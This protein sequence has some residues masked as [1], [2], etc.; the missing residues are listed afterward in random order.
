MAI[1][2][3]IGIIKDSVGILLDGCDDALLVRQLTRDLESLSEIESF[4]ELRVW[5]LNRGKYCACVQVVGAEEGS[6]ALEKVKRIF[7]RRE[8]QSFV[9]VGKAKKN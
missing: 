9:E 5:S 6:D 7:E 2:S 1:Y 3:T 8:V 4:K